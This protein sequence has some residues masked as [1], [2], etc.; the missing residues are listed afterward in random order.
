[1]VLL[2]PGE[3]KVSGPLRAASQYLCLV[4]LLDGPWAYAV[5]SPA[6]RCSDFLARRNLT[7]YRTVSDDHN[8]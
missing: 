5:G 7:C 4:L 3:G 8:S 1:M 2:Q 6:S